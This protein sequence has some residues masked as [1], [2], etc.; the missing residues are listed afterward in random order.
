MVVQFEGK[1][2]HFTTLINYQAHQENAPECLTL[3]HYTD[4]AEEKGIVLMVGEFDT[5][6]LVGSLYR[7]S[8]FKLRSTFIVAECPGG[9]VL[10]ES[11]GAVL[12]QSVGGEV[13]AIEDLH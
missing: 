3:T 5:N 10:G 8:C 9:A 4:L 6:V 7:Q 13:E 12:L 1:E 2:A 11:G